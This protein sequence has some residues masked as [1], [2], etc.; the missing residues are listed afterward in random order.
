LGSAT[1]GAL[2]RPLS[3]A[4]TLRDAPHSRPARIVLML[5]VAATIAC[6]ALGIYQVNMSWNGLP[7]HLGPIRFSMTIYPPL[8][9]CVW[10]VF[11]LSFER[12]LLAA[13][14]ATWTLSLYEG[15][16]LKAASLFALVHPLALAVYALAYRT[17][18][19]PF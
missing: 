17:A 12:A 19:L 4:K 10:M 14:L 11:W 5:W 7:I 3:L 2:W 13:H 8:I 15:M 16:P 6:I 9:I 18:R 1:G